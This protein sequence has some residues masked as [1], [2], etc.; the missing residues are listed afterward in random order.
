MARLDDGGLWLHG[1]NAGE[2]GPC[3]L[4]RVGANREVSRIADEGAKLTKA[5]NA[6]DARRRPRND[7]DPS[8]EFHGHACRARERVRVLA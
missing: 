4:E 8:A 2:R 3:E 1:E 6:T 5:T 7:D